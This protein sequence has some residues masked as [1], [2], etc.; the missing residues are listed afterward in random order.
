MKIL[1][2]GGSGGI[3]SAMVKEALASFPDAEVHA[4]FYTRNI[5]ASSAHI[6]GVSWHRLDV[7]DEAAIKALSESFESLDWLI[8][9]VGM[10]HTASKGPEKSLSQ[11]DGEFFLHN[12]RL[13]TLPTLLLAKHFSA[14]LKSS[15]SPRLA[16]LS[17]R[18]GS[19]SDNRLGGWYSYRASKAALNMLI[20]TL[21]VDWQRS[22]KRGV[23]LALHPGTTKTRLSAPFQANVPE[24]KL[25]LPE[26][27][28]ADLMG[29]IARA[30]VGDSGSFLAYDG[31]TI[32][33]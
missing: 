3:G 22:L 1:I 27:V 4:T 21:A 25:F 30:E 29:I 14:K 8:N 9:C 18:V 13:N 15:A 24:D 16:V 28:A 20:K 12:M 26:R 6:P 7:T 17:A 31:A 32:S 11:F 23:V 19:I 5:M 33:W 10:L 2:V